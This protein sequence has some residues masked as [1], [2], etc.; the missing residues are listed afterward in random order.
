MCD[1]CP[2]LS[3][4]EPANQGHFAST[5]PMIDEETPI[6]FG[7]MEGVFSTVGIRNIADRAHNAIDAAM[8]N[9]I[10]LRLWHKK[11]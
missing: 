5:A 6:S 7:L 4:F 10:L 9:K 2:S 8:H 1:E 11:P 3:A